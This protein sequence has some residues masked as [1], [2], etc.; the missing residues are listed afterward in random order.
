MERKVSVIVPCY[1]SADHLPALLASLRAQTLPRRRFEVLI[2]HNGPDDGAE[3]LVDPFLR[4]YPTLSIRSARV[5]EANVGV[6]RNHGLDLARYPFC[7]FV[8][9]DD[10]LTET[11]LQ[12]LLD[13]GDDGDVT[14]AQI[15]DVHPDGRVDTDTP[16]NQHI[17]ERQGQ[18]LPVGRAPK[19]AGFVACKLLKTS[20]ARSTQFDTSLRSGE[21]VDF[22]DRY[23]MLDASPL[24]FL[25][26][27]SRAVYRRQVRAGSLSRRPLAFDFSVT[28]RFEVMGR[29]LSRE[30]DRRTRPLLSSALAGQAWHTNAYLR[31]QP[32]RR[33]E[34]VDL[35][36]QRDLPDAVLA[37]INRGLATTLVASYCFPPY[38][39][40]S[41][42]VAAKRLLAWGEPYDVIQNEMSSA[43]RTDP[44]LGLL[45]RTLLADRTTVSS[46]TA[47]GVWSTVEAFCSQAV[48]GLQDGGSGPSA[49]RLYSRAMW[50][51]SHVLGALLKLRDPSLHWV[52]EFSDPLLVD[53]KG[54]RRRGVI[55]PGSAL[56]ELLGPAL[57]AAGIPPTDNLF[58]LA[59][60]L[61]IGLADELVYTND[62]QLAMMNGYRTPELAGRASAKASVVPQ[63]T[64]PRSFYDL[65]TPST[66]LS[67]A[68]VRIGYFG[69]P[70]PTRDLSDVIRCMPDHP[71]A[72]LYLV[73][74]G[75]EAEVE[76]QG[77]SATPN[78]EVVGPVGYLESLALMTGMDVLVISDTVPGHG[79]PGSPYLPSKLSDYRGSG[80]PVWGLVLAGSP[81]DGTEL[82][83]RSPLGDAG[84]ADAVLSQLS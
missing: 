24:F 48:A 75:W 81:L 42:I 15:H 30:H 57:G 22:M 63:P 84:A 52:A 77:A 18:R 53:V 6:A 16:L 1:R 56:M 51:H 70:A 20:L 26:T 9:H 21:D 66:P 65:A 37:R 50:P 27:S 80:T 25:P 3:Q 13:G 35:A 41:G 40:P 78:I 39:D 64:L 71:G 36:V 10:Q 59:E 83:H 4:R 49:Q 8:D 28:E 69:A 46:P 5:G 17:V 34:V 76:R 58:D 31:Q 23:F 29:L 43:R 60:L 11:Y 33:A 47:F 74:A 61:P 12:A 7:T 67:A 45:T 82:A 68:G 2:V 44:A 72:T 19:V 32:R 54:N 79:V 62:S 73:G 38:V 14:V 55:P